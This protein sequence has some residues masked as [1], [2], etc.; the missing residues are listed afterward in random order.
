MHVA[1]IGGGIAGSSAALRLREAGAEVTLLEAG[2]R[3]GGLV[4][5]FEVAGTPLE[6]FYHHVFPNEDLIV[7]LIG[8]LGLQQRLSWLPSS[9]GVLSD[10][11]VWP[12]T[13]PVDLLRFGPLRPWQRLQL[14]VGALRLV[15]TRD[16]KAL[17]DRPAEDWLRSTT[18]AAAVDALWRP[19][20]RAKFGPAAATVP[21]AWMWGRFQQRKAA[22][23]GGG[24][25][26]GYLRGGFRQLFDA[27]N[28]R[29]VSTGVNVRT[30]IR[31]SALS[32]DGRRATGVQTDAGDISAD[33]VLYTGAMPGLQRLVPGPFA[34]PRWDARGLGVL[35]VVVE[36]RTRLTDVYWTNVCDPALPFG[37]IIEHTNLVPAADYAGRHVIY[38]SR[39]FTADE[40]V[41][42][43]DP[44]E[45]AA[46]WLASLHERYPHFE[47]SAVIAVHPFR[48][49]YAAPLVDLGYGKRLAP[50]HAEQ[51]ER[52]YVCTT[53]QIYPHD[54]GMNE[55][56]VKATDAVRAITADL[57]GPW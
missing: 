50:L 42:T 45:E 55:G 53:A 57:G 12:F 14:G 6:C 2:P 29:L 33:A 43:A 37:G 47:P 1:V 23:H 25:T 7:G 41:A 9:M 3:L 24:E 39:Y 40:D 4:V 51:L 35:C 49:P 48:T 20:L 56:V 34:D 11:E 46:R 17:D 8:E 38:L 28:D 26:L 36:T 10:G 15:R 22:R 30:G 32:V 27:V 13:T 31:V 44:E 19:L 18:G 52:L 54:R 21:A 16:W 5:S